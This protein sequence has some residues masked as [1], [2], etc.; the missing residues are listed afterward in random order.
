MNTIKKKYLL[1]IH[2]DSKKQF[3]IK[4]ENDHEPLIF[5]YDF[6]ASSD[7]REVVIKLLKSIYDKISINISLDCN[8]ND[9]P[10]HRVKQVK[11]IRRFK[12]YLYNLID[13]Y[14]TLRIYF[15]IGGPDFTIDISKIAH[16]DKGEYIS[17]KHIPQDIDFCVDTEFES[18]L[19]ID[20]LIDAA[21]IINETNKEV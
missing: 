5:K 2:L 3:F 9:I 16:D 7:D 12:K 19:D 6:I 1:N 4:P 18:N 10:N 13:I 15:C 11:T 21:R 8:L 14:D 20:L 17:Y